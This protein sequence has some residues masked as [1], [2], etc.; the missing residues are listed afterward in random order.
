MYWLGSGAVQRV[1]VASDGSQS[2]G[3]TYDVAVDGACTRVAF[4]ADATNLAQTTSGGSAHPNYKGAKTG[5][6][7]GGSSRSTCA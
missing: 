4:I 7:P 1:S 2:N 3:S 5:A 6:T